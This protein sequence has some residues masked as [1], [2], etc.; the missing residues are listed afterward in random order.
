MHSG[1]V[2]GVLRTGPNSASFP[3]QL[4]RLEKGGETTIHS[5]STESI[6]MVQDTTPEECRQSE[7]IQH[8]FIS[9]HSVD[10]KEGSQ[11]LDQSLVSEGIELQGTIKDV[12]P[13]A[14]RTRSCRQ[15]TRSIRIDGNKGGFGEDTNRNNDKE[16]IQR[17]ITQNKEQQNTIDE[18]SS[19][20]KEFLKVQSTVKKLQG[21]I[22]KLS[23]QLKSQMK[24]NVQVSS[25][26]QIVK[27]F[28]PVDNSVDVPVRHQPH[29][30]IQ[31]APETQYIQYGS[32]HE[33]FQA[34]FRRQHLGTK[35]E[36]RCQDHIEPCASEIKTVNS[37]QHEVNDSYYGCDDS[38]VDSCITGKS[39]PRKH[40]TQH[41]AFMATPVKRSRATLPTRCHQNTTNQVSDEYNIDHLEEVYM[42]V[43]MHDKF[44]LDKKEMERRRIQDARV[45]SHKAFTAQNH[46]SDSFC[47]SNENLEAE[48]EQSPSPAYSEESDCPACEDSVEEPE[49]SRSPSPVPVN[50]KEPIKRE[51]YTVPKDSKEDRAKAYAR[52]S[53]ALD[54]VDPSVHLN[55]KGKRTTAT[56]YVGN[57]EFN[58]NEQDLRQAL[59]RIFK[60]IRVDKITIP[61][62]HGRSKYGFIEISWAHRAPVKLADLCIKYSGMIQVNSR[63]IYFRELRNK[64]DKN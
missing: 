41:S 21:N 28:T 39:P 1:G 26:H 32:L 12:T 5:Q 52:I 64:D 63:P 14:L 58:A 46:E 29:S 18:L 10:D 23:K 44:L 60:R 31:N 53:K 56:L 38:D 43:G 19:A 54:Q 51:R 55:P 6:Q 42:S 22:E 49:Q 25:S 61:R 3:E 57:L 7:K 62:V 27:P 35:C 30:E 16:L 24:F 9:S 15:Q 34:H 36:L 50:R 2:P 47:S 8:S 40:C 33:A 45:E 17:L 59:D 11:E 13:V 4:P 48:P 20:V 37:C